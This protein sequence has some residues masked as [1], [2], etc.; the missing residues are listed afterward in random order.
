M[1]MPHPLTDF[2]EEEGEISPEERAKFGARPLSMKLEIML[3][4]V[5]KHC[6]GSSAYIKHLEVLK[7][8][9]DA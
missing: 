5:A 7:Q 1:E 4:L 9:S 6:L 2:T 3:L 8:Y